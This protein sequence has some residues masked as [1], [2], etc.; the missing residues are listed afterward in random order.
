MVF[1]IFPKIAYSK[2]LYLN[3]ISTAARKICGRS[4]RSHTEYKGLLT[5][6]WMI[7]ATYPTG[8]CHDYEDYQR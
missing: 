1:K 6:N 4:S 8:K 5:S 7:R 3:T 2:D